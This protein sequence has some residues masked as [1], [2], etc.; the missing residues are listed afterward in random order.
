[1]IAQKRPVV[2]S[3]RPSGRSDQLVSALQAAGYRTRAVPTVNLEPGDPAALDRHLRS[4][5]PGDWVVVTSA[6]GARQVIDALRRRRLPLRWA[7]VGPATARVLSDGGIRP[8]VVPDDVRGDALPQALLAE[9]PLAGRRVLL[10]RADAA[11][12]RLPAALRAAGAEVHEVVAYRTIEAPAA[13]LRPLAAALSDPDLAAI[14]I[15]SGSALRGLLELAS[16]L[17]SASRHRERLEAV[18]LVSIGPTTS[19]AITAAGLPVAAEAAH[20]SVAGLL[21]AVASVAS[22][23]SIASRPTPKKETDH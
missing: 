13:S 5:R 23:A 22:V 11:D 8:R 21:S 4:L 17:P 1:M 12:E 9:G 2:L 14:V 16:R 10:P 3:T 20:P 6:T 19:A 18:P 15:A 7:A